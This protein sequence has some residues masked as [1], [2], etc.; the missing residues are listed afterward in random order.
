LVYGRDPRLPQDMIVHL[1]HRNLRKITPSDLNIYKSSLLNTL[2]QTFENLQNHKQSEAL[3]YKTYYD[4]S[5]KQIEY[6]IGEKVQIY[7]PIAENETLK[8]KLGKRWRGP[9]E[10]IARVDPVTYRIKQEG[11]KTIKIFQYM[12]RE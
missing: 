2:R 10:I 4:K 8:Y 5:H 12:Y 6:N 9:F 7:Y 1:D 3:K 11:R